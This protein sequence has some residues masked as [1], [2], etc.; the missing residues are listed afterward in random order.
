MTAALA[1]MTSGFRDATHGAQQTF[2]TLLDA[3]SRPGRV[4]TFPHGALDGIE[5]PASGTPGRPMGLGATATLLALLDAETTVTLHGATASHAATAYLRFHT[6][7]RA[8]EHG[9]AFT[10]ARAGELNA[11]LWAGLDLGSDEVPQNGA[12]LLIEVDGFEIAGATPLQLRGPGIESTQAL[13]VAGPP[14]AFW[15]WRLDLQAL[16]PRGIDLVL[17]HGTQV[18]AIPRST[19]LSLQ[20][21]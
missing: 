9:A 11:A 1:E 18:A 13:H 2:R 15:R 10:L 5:P 19:R 6:G 17:V 3:M 7:V 14:E 21:A 20:G 4:F 8:V 12:T 16:L